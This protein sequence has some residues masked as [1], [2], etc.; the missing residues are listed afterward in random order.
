M[1][2][3]TDFGNKLF[4]KPS[5][6]WYDIHQQ[7]SEDLLRRAFRRLNHHGFT[8]YRGRQSDFPKTI[9]P[10]V[11]C[12]PP[13]HLPK[14]RLVLWHWNAGQLSP[15]RYQELLR[16]LH[17]QNVDIA[18]SSETHLQYSNE[19]STSQWHFIHTG[20]DSTH[21]Y[22]K[23]SGLRILVAKHV[24]QAHQISWHAVV[25]GRILHCRLHLDCKSFDIFGVYQYPWNTLTAQRTRRQTIWKHL[26]ST[27]QAIPQGNTLYL[28]VDFNC[29][30]CNIA[31]LVGTSTFL[32]L[33][34]RKSGPQPGDMADFACILQDFFSDYSH[35]QLVT[36]AWC[37]VSI[38]C[39]WIPYWLYFD[40]A[41]RCWQHGKA[42]GIDSHSA[43]S[44]GQFPSCT[45]WPAFLTNFS[46][47]P[48]LIMVLHGRQSRHV[49]RRRC[50]TLALYL[51]AGL[52]DLHLML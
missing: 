26:G 30:L 37:Y 23:T 39:W 6:A 5:C 31:R 45:S 50:T 35:K 38:S 12:Q 18:L 13:E 10:N 43:F 27:L 17:Q 36:S 4:H 41:Q 22:D 52:M 8:W 34:G 11:P 33:G 51:L 42:G 21:S 9:T 25:P 40:Q 49:F 1:R 19:W 3:Q 15:G 44:F 47:L 24:W 29:S 48:D 16:Y 20:S 14:H 46:D 32:S 2:Y 28:M 7:S